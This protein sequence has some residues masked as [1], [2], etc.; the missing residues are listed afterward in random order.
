VAVHKMFR[1]VEPFKAWITS[2][3]DRQRDRQNYD[4][5][6]VVLTTRYKIRLT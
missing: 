6:S 2:V 1:C 3:V 4:S 5:N